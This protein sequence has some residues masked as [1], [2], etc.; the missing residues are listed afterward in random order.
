MVLL[1]ASS[2]WNTCDLLSL[3]GLQ[4]AL[5]VAQPLEHWQDIVLSWLARPLLFSFHSHSPATSFPV[6]GR[7]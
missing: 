1:K 2:V 6:C 7:D 5:I 3:I 4:L